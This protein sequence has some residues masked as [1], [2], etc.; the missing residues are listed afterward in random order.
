M[1]LVKFQICIQTPLACSTTAPLRY[2]K[3]LVIEGHRLIGVNRIDRSICMNVMF[4]FDRNSRR[5]ETACRLLL[6]MTRPKGRSHDNEQ[7]Q[8]PSNITDDDV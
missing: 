5:L 2:A 7:Q 3:F 4:H 6:H 1:L 8:L